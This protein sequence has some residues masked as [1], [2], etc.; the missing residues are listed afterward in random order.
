[1][2]ES[3]SFLS[4]GVFL[5]LQMYSSDPLD[6]KNYAKKQF[7]R[8]E[9]IHMCSHAWRVHV[10]FYTVP[11]DLFLQWRLSQG[12]QEQKYH[13]IRSTDS[14]YQHRCLS[15]AAFHSHIQAEK[16]YVNNNM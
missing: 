9:A 11:L 5:L 15:E 16:H 13:R 3:F 2:P 14:D 12:R 7:L 1:M 10:Q 8:P 4:T 6:T